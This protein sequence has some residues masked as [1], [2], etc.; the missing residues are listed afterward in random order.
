[1]RAVSVNNEYEIEVLRSELHEQSL[2]ISQL[3]R[4]IKDAG[5]QPRF[6][7]KIMSR[8]RKEWPTL[9]AAI[10][11]I[12]LFENNQ[13]KAADDAYQCDCVKPDGFTYYKFVTVCDTCLTQFPYYDCYCELQHDNCNDE[14]RQKNIEYRT[15]NK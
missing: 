5:P 4:A 12:L 7:E 1:M 3:R 11:N 10:D 9:W 6:H 2:A 14:T 13:F 15:V 8:H